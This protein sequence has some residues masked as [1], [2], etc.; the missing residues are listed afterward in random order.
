MSKNLMQTEIQRAFLNECS[1]DRLKAIVGEQRSTTFLSDF[2]LLAEQTG[3]QDYAQL[4]RCC[5]E[6]ASMNLPILKQ[7]GQAYVVPRGGRLNVEIGYR[8]WLVLAKRAGIAVR[9]YV[10]CEG[11]SMEF[12][13][14]GFEQ[15]FTYK[16]LQDNLANASSVDWL[17]DNLR[18]IAVVTK[19][20]ATGIET[21]SLVPFDVIK[22][23]QGL[24]QKNQAYSTWAQEMYVAKAIKYVLKKL[25]I[26][27]LDDGIFRAFAKDDEADM[28]KQGA[29]VDKPLTPTPTAS[30]NP[31]DSFVSEEVVE[32]V[33]EVGEVPV[34]DFE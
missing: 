8:G 21:T 34:I 32:Y 13:A 16:P 27:T 23:M 30:S 17:N 9:H 29:V 11:D 14:R 4:A 33:E 19:D 5:V 22:K 24:A 2:V 1:M 3:S 26:D 25:P 20:L 18:F 12:E 6:I 10:I 7:A 31:L 15:F 28:V